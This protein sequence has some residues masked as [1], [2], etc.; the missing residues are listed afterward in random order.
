[1]NGINKN[2]VLLLIDKGLA[3]VNFSLVIILLKLRRI[4]KCKRS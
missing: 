1:M 4:W 2:E 3:S